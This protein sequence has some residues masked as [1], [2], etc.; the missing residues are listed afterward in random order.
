MVDAWNPV[1]RIALEAKSGFQCFQCIHRLPNGRRITIDL[2]NQI[3]AD[4]L[5]KNGRAFAKVEWYFFANSS[6]V[7]AYDP[8]LYEALDNAGIAYVLHLP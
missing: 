8:K 3:D 1:E 6:G 7:M 5:V 2:Q 4:V